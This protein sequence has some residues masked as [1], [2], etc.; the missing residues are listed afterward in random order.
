M[1]AALDAA[2]DLVDGLAEGVA[3]GQLVDAGALDVAGDAEEARAAVAFGAELG[4]G[5]AAHEQDVRGVGDGLGIVDDRGAAVEADDGREGRLD[6][7]HAALAFERLHQRGLFADL[8]GA[9]AGLGDDVEVDAL[10]PKM[11]LP[12]KPLA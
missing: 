4:V 11:F 5:L 3:H 7:G 8:V 12:R 9:G 2:G 6:A 1:L 10:V